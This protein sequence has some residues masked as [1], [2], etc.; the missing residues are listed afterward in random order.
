VPNNVI[1]RAVILAAGRG[2]RMGSLTETMPKPLLPVQGRPLLDYVFERLSH[3]GIEEF[4]LVIGHG[5]KQISHHVKS[6]K[7]KVKFVEQDP[8]DGT[9]TAALLAEE[10]AGNEPFLLTFGDI[11]CSENEYQRLQSVL[12]KWPAADAVIAVKEVNDPWQGAA[13]YEIG[14]R[15]TR[16]VE[17]P[18]KGTSS[19]RWNSAG[20]FL[21][22]PVLFSYLKRVQ[23]SGRGEYELTSA[24]EAMLRDRM[25]L[26]ISAVTGSW[27]DVGRP[28]DLEALNASIA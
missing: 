7:Y 2:R 18:P 22:K 11:L 28:E 25:E 17:K 20:I 14:G 6:L 9:G 19:T 8:V 5:G 24:F 23:L 13:V 4:L 12:Q 1:R 27:R 21:C 10:F 16:I 3:A 26:H 15:I